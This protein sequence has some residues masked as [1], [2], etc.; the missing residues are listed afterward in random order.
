[1]PAMGGNGLA[2][3]A[4][5]FLD[6][7]ARVFDVSLL[8]V[9][10]SVRKPDATIPA[11]VRDRSIRAAVL[12]IAGREDPHF[13]LI[14]CLRDPAERQRALEAYPVPLRCRFA[15]PGL[16]REAHAAFSGET[17][18]V[19]HVMRL[20]LAPFAEPYLRQR[21]GRPLVTLD[22]DD[23]E[24]HAH[25]R[26]AAL[27]ADLGRI[28]AEQRE[29]SEARRFATMERH[30]LSRFDRVFVCSPGDRL[31]LE[32]TCENVCSEIIPNAVVVPDP[33]PARSRDPRFDCLFVGALRYQPNADAV[34]YF[35]NR[36]L[37]ELRGRLGRRVTIGIVGSDPPGEIRALVRFDGV[38][39]TG[40][41]PDVRPYY[42]QAASAVVPIRAG[43]GT[44][45]KLLEAFALGVPVVATS[46]G[47]DGI[48][49]ADGEQ[50][51]VADDA[52]A[53]AA[54][55]H[56]VLADAELADRLVESAW[57]L[58]R[59]RYS[60]T[61]VSEWIGRVFTGALADGPR[62]IRS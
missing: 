13:R 15:T 23:V 34:Q 27:N 9:P 14:M 29:R 7:L 32:Q 44:R 21:T 46:I 55:C 58:A 31:K 8:V 4:G 38:T 19:V 48:E 33:Q 61:V 50:L 40:T 36:V 41:V 57:C 24:S 2:M 10:V 54:A 51:L 18:D 56:R 20:Y 47:C 1:M 39:V 42:A 26:L 35:C 30:Y 52:A 6:A 22:L 17:F 28:E 37:P 53:F 60:T 45:I 49:A 25:A 12:P 5:M 11:F 59:T 16:V 3:R 43:G 62:P